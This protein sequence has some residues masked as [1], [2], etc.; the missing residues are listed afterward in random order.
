MKENAVIL[1]LKLPSK[2]KVK[3]RLEKDLAPEL[4][5]SLYNAFISDILN[6]CSTADADTIIAYLPDSEAEE[7]HKTL[8][9]GYTS[10]RQRGCDLGER[11]FNAF[12]DTYGSGYRW[13][14]LIGSDIPAIRSN[15]LNDAFRMLE[16]TDIAIGPSSDGGYYLLGN[17]AVSNSDVFYKDIEWSSPDVYEKTKSR[18]ELHGYSMSRLEIL[19]DIDNLSDLVK[20]YETN[21]GDTASMSVR[22]I[23]ENLELILKV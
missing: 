10:F 21:C 14:V 4:V 8:L 15:I 3:T 2:G 11:M 6:A 17:T 7:E 1:F 9:A 23:T 16:K 18:I 20:F 13:C 12:A 19:N 22:V 5:L